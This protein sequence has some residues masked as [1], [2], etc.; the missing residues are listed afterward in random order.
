MSLHYAKLRKTARRSRHVTDL[1]TDLAEELQGSKTSAL[2]SVLGR[3]Y[4]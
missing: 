3:N 1:Q 4:F 2:Q